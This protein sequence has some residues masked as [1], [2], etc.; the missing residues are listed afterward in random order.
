MGMPKKL[1]N[2][3]SCFKIKKFN[4][5]KLVF[6]TAPIYYPELTD[7]EIEV[8]YKRYGNTIGSSWT[9]TLRREVIKLSDHKTSI[10][11][12][13]MTVEDA[14]I[15]LSAGA[16]AIVISNHGGRVMDNTPGT[17]EILPII[18]EEVKGKIKI[19]D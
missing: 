7:I 10:K 18:A 15:A 9:Y 6:K 11:K 16:T 4:E 13:V 1:G 19:I 2:D 14:Q 8:N 12:G 5:S 3:W 17:A